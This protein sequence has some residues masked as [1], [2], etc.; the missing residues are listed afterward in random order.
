MVYI[1]CTQK[2][3]QEFKGRLAAEAHVQSGIHGWHAGLYRFSR[4]KCVLAVNDAARF[5]VFLPGLRKPDFQNFATL[6]RNRLKQELILFQIPVADAARAVL[7]LGPLTLGKTHSRSVLGSMND[8]AIC[9][10]VQIMRLGGLPETGGELDWISRS[11]NETPRT[12]K[13]RSDFFIPAEEM[14]RLIS[15][16]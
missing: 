4:R 15:G 2:L 8:M 11:V 5:A 1:G 7:G 6:F 9:L 12:I 3:A 16:L 13:G 14:K 10:D